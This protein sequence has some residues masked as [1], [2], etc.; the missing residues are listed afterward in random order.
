[1]TTIWLS[2]PV[3][4]GPMRSPSSPLTI[5]S[6]APAS[7]GTAT[8]SPFCAGSSPSSVGDDRRERSEHDPDH[9]RDVEIEKSSEQRRRVARLPEAGRRPCR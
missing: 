2:V 1:M 6:T 8:I 3:V 5:R 4:F 7:V 9:E